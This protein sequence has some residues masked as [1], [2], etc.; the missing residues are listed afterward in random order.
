[1]QCFEASAPLDDADGD[2][3]ADLLHR[4][5]V[6]KP[7]HRWLMLLVI[8]CCTSLRLMMML[9]VMLMLICCTGAVS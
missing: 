1:V 4:C 2:A 6:L 7:R 3:D 9:M 8:F 5:S